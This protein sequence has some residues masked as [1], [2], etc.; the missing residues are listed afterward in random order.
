MAN[1]K[2]DFLYLSEEDTIKAGVLNMEKCVKTMEEAFR[3][4]G[5][6]DYIMGGGSENEHGIRL[7]FPVEKRFPRMPTKGPDRRFMAMIAYVGGRFNV[8]GEK[9]YG[10]NVNN[11]QAGLPRSI[12]FVILN[13]P[14][15]AEPLV[16]MAGNL[17]SSMRTGAVP[18]LGAKYLARKD[19]K[20]IGIVGAG[21][22]GKTCLLGLN[23]VLRNI[24]EVKVYDIM[25]SQSKV[26]CKE[27]GK[28]L[29]MDL[30][31]V[32]SAEDAIRGSDVVNAAAS[33]LK[34]TII[35][36]E[37]LK[38][39][40]FLSLSA[41]AKLEKDLLVNSTIVLDELKMH[42]ATYIENEGLSAEKKQ[43]VPSLLLFKYIKDKI[44]KEKDILS[45]GEIVLGKTTGRS[46]E[47]QNI[48][49]MAGGMP[50]EDVAW[51]FSVYK[52]AIQMGIGKRLKLWNRPH[53]F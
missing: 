2:G 36:R 23:V 14:E 50:V 5:K 43:D 12:H 37:W 40:V 46:N 7:H 18:A 42:K 27:M 47:T 29:K 25:P 39:G 34:P 49:L 22:I 28:K 16:V 4:V 24:K 1:K 30:H 11:R 32:E 41:T 38:E 3:L 48:V 35:K 8:C 52:Q 51:S 19:S 26:Y 15:T 10:S 53:W 31:P 45:L 13:N 6:G 20:V 21:V 33:R 17:V 44:I 9:W